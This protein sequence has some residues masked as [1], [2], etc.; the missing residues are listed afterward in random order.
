MQLH[1]K[2]VIYLRKFFE[3]KCIR[4]LYFYIM[5]EPII[6]EFERTGG[7]A[8]ITLHVYVNSAELPHDEALRLKELW[9]NSALPDYLAESEE[10]P[11]YPDSFVY[12]FTVKTG[13]REFFIHLKEDQVPPS[14]RPLIRYLTTK[15]RK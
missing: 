9:I 7:F 15:A 14:A 13:D 12:S 5:D 11:A 3:A 2:D 1:E 10:K 8:G 6:I 4:Q